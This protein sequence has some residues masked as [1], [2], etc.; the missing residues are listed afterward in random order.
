MLE[1]SST[2]TQEVSN[3]IISLSQWM[4]GVRP[5]E[6]VPE[7]ELIQLDSFEACLEH[8]VVSY[9]VTSDLHNHVEIKWIDDK[10]KWQSAIS[11]LPWCVSYA[12]WAGGRMYLEATDY[13]Q[14]DENGVPHLSAGL[15]LRGLHA[16]VEG[17]GVV[18]LLRLHLA[19]RDGLVFRA[20][21]DSS[22]SH[23]AA[24]KQIWSPLR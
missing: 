9:A 8:G 21:G 19:G 11:Y 23:I 13:L 14:Y 3:T 7:A 18:L 24:A 15:S 5:G 20:I 1:P 10:G 17:H 12:T 16:T 6:E 4:A 2:M 22:G